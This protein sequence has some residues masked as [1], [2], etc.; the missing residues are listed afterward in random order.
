MARIATC[1]AAVIFILLCPAAAA[2]NWP[3]KPIRFIVPFAAAGSTD[4]V[5]RVIAERL[6]VALGRQIIVDSKIS[7]AE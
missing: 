3:A 2:Q 6:S 4:L 1:C 7:V 5:A